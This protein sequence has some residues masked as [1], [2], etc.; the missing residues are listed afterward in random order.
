MGRQLSRRRVSTASPQRPLFCSPDVCGRS[1]SIGRC[2]RRQFPA[3]S[4]RRLSLYRGRRFCRIGIVISSGCVAAIS[5]DQHGRGKRGTR[6]LCA[7]L[8]SNICLLARRLRG[9]QFSFATES[10]A[11]RLRFLGLL[12]SEFRTFCARSWKWCLYRRYG[13]RATTRALNSMILSA[14]LDGV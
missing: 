12:G 2:F 1:F 8:P 13:H 7:P 9:S 4:V 5:S 11:G 14:G 6:T 10:G 3:R